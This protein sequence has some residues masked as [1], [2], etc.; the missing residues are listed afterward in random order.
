VLL[1]A[2]PEISIPPES[3][4]FERFSSSFESYGNLH[5]QK[6]IKAFV[7]DVLKDLRIKEWRLRISVDNL[8][9]SV[10][11]FSVSGVVS[12]LFQAYA[13]REGKKYWGDKTPQHMFYLKEIKA[14]FPNAK[15][16]HIVRDGRDIAESM[17][18]TSIGPNSVYRVAKRWKAYVS[19]FALFKRENSSEQVL[20]VSYEG[21]IRRQRHELHRIFAFLNI[22]P[23]VI[24]EPIPNTLRRDQY[25]DTAPLHRSLGKSISDAK[26]GIFRTALSQ[27]ELEIFE[28]IAGESLEDY[29]YSPVTAKNAQ[30]SRYEKMSRFQLIP[31]TVDKVYI[32][33]TSPVCRS[34]Q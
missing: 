29:G 21:L 23:R 19:T 14:A 22:S 25:I 27:R 18:R 17:K 8:C 2:H 3:H 31:F 11:S 15:F 10:Q 16:I 30:I 1:D 7:S 24:L 28:S 32:D 9:H 6:N 13:Q 33:W 20:E 4:F 12:A 5:N 34:I 26:I